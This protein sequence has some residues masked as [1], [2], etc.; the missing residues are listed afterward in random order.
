MILTVT[1]NPSIDTR[2]ELSCLAIDDVN[3]ATPERTP[4]GKG[5]NVSRVLA[6]LGEGVVATGLVGGH[7]GAL[8]TELLDSEGIAHEFS[9]IAGETRICLSILHEGNQTEIL[10]SGPEVSGAELDRFFETLRPLASRADMVTA[11]GSLPRGVAPDA[12]SR[13]LATCARAGCGEV[14]LDSSGVPLERALV[15]PN[16]PL[17]V[18]PNLSEANALMGTDL[19][20]SDAEGIVRA[21]RADARLGRVPWVVVS[22]G[23]L[24]C[25]AEH[26]GRAWRATPPRV[27]AVNATGSGD[28][29]LAGL[30]HAI[31]RGMDE[32]DVLR[33]AVTCGTL[34]AMDPRTGHVPLGCWDEVER[35]VRVEPV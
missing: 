16:A 6:Q 28:A 7:L 12:Y 35:A 8:L 32:A 31:S 1:M 18:K 14:L 5:L 4:G 34:N 25:V 22:L 10:E 19:D 30:A 11:S 33:V 21:V 23:R 24:G 15:G 9:R 20:S 26:D 17:L 27:A 2:Y 3:R 29:M 13:L